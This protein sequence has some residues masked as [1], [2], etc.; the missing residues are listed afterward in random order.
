MSDNGVTGLPSVIE[1][2]TQSGVVNHITPLSLFTVLGLRTKAEEQFAYPGDAPYR[3]ESPQVATGYIPASENPEYQAL[4]KAV[5]EQREEWKNHAAIEL[6]VKFPQW[7]SRD[8]MIAHFRPRLEQLR[9]YIKLGGDEWQNVLEHCV[10]TGQTSIKGESG[11]SV[12]SERVMVVHLAY[13]NRSVPL[14]AP[15]V[16]DGLRIFRLA[17]PGNGTGKLARQP[18]GAGEQSP[19]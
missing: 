12:A 9:P 17:V 16:V 8:A 4:C 10:Y 7:S 1:Y 6:A 13:Q 2:E 15:E 3:I 19:N 5:D 18:S 11:V 14:S